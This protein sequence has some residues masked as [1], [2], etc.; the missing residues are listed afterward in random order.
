MGSRPEK[1]LIAEI[2]FDL[3]QKK[4]TV[5]PALKE[6]GI[7]TMFRSMFR[8]SAKLHARLRQI[9]TSVSS[10]GGQVLYLRIADPYGQRTQEK[11]DV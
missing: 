6:F 2:V 5:Y 10:T 4:A 3:S 8:S 1:P 9:M 7:L 11:P